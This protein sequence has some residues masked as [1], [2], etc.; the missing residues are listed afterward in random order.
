MDETWRQAIHKKINTV[1]FYFYKLFRV[2]K[3]KEME[4]RM[5]VTRDWRKG[6]KGSYCLMAELY[7]MDI[8]SDL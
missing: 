2:A 8:V 3:F 6:E 4:N 7:L 5:V 1:W